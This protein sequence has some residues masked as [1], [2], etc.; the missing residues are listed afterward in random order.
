[1]LFYFWRG[2]LYLENNAL[3]FYENPVINHSLLKIGDFIMVLSFKVKN[4]LSFKDYA[5]FEMYASNYDKTK[6]ENVIDLDEKEKNNLVKQLAIYGPN[7]SGK[8]NIVEAYSLLKNIILGSLKDDDVPLRNITFANTKE[9]DDSVE[10]ELQFYANEIDK[11]DYVVVL[12]NGEILEECLYKR[13][14]DRFALVVSRTYDSNKNKYKIKHNNNYNTNLNKF[15]DFSRKKASILSL[16]KNFDNDTLRPIVNY[17]LASNVVTSSNKVCKK[18]NYYSTFAYTNNEGFDVVRP[19]DKRI[20]GI[21]THLGLGIDDIHIRENGER[22]ETM[23]SY[24]GLD[25]DLSAYENSNGTNKLFNIALSIAISLDSGAPLFI[26]ELDSNIHPLAA[27][28]IIELFSSKRNRRNAQLIFTT[29]NPYFLD[30]LRRDQIWFCEKDK[31]VSHLYPLKSFK[32][33]NDAVI[34]KRYMSGAFGAIP[35]IPSNWI[36]DVETKNEKK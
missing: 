13:E 3:L 9:I 28:K 15:S 8:S 6:I 11:Y 2:K 16:L 33:R 10:L 34:S 14:P 32:M 36:E 29:H 30:D 35:F 21:I 31:A 4:F 27:K 22:K 1:M 18:F 23:F 26:D 17:F 24:S 5:S 25:R 7:A 12:K 20:R 19:I